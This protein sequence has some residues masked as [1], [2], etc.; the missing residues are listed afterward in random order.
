MLFGHLAQ[1][2]GKQAIRLFFVAE[3]L[4]HQRNA[5]LQALFY[6]ALR[7]NRVCSELKA[8]L[9]VEAA[10]RGLTD[11]AAIAQSMRFVHSESV[12]AAT[13]QESH[14]LEALL[15]GIAFAEVW[16]LGVPVK[17]AHDS[18]VRDY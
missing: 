8:G 10:V 14:I 11:S 16:L 15:R 12:L 4:F 2:F 9:G 13:V 17:A 3:H 5:L 1:L 7:G 6:F 18:L